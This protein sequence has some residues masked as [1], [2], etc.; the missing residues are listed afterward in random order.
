VLLSGLDQPRVAALHI[1]DI[2]RLVAG[3][4]GLGIG[5]FGLIGRLNISSSDNSA[6]DHS[7][8]SV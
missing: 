4:A 8:G 2:M 7:K 3:G 1:P 5:L 6:Q